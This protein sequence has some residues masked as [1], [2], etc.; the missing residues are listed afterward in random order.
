LERLAL[1]GEAWKLLTTKFEQ[2]VSHW[3]GSENIVKQTYSDK[4]YQRI[5]S[6]AKHK[7]LFG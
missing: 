4:H 6:T 5:S 3:A 2:Q 7:S 1:T